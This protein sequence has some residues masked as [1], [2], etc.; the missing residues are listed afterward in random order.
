M[1]LL[2]DTHIWIWSVGE[3]Q[4]LTRRVAKEL[5]DAQNELWLS[6]VSIW[7]ALLLHRK[8]RLKIPEGF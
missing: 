7:E 6:P 8:H 3:P 5:D 2:L 1:K 4:R